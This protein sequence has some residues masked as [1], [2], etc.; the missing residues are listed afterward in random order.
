MAVVED[1][2]GG[3][4]H[5][6]LRDVTGEVD[7]AGGQWGFKQNAVEFGSGFKAPADTQ[8]DK[9]RKEI[10][11]LASGSA[12]QKEDEKKRAKKSFV[13]FEGG[14]NPYREAEEAQLPTYLKKHGTALESPALAVETLPLSPMQ[15]T[16]LLK[17]KLEAMGVAWTGEHLKLLQRRW[18]EGIR[19]ADLDEAL[20]LLRGVKER[21]R[22][23]AVG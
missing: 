19:E 13:A 14:I 23:V 6:Q 5:I 9:N 2:N 21:P 18:P 22:L 20:A 11:L 4:R 12:T 10:R 7:P 1:E 3:E 8:I 17:P 16:K 15:A